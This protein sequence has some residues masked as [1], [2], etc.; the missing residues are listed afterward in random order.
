MAILILFKHQDFSW[1]PLV[2]T[3]MSIR[4]QGENTISFFV[5]YHFHPDSYWACA[6]DSTHHNIS[7][8]L[9]FFQIFSSGWFSLVTN[10]LRHLIS[11]YSSPIVLLWIFSI[12]PVWNLNPK[13]FSSSSVLPTRAVTSCCSSLTLSAFTPPEPWATKLQRACLFLIQWFF[14]SE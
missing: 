13:H 11:S 6:T 4:H 9:I 8:F 1:V 3:D 12:F 7:G 5:L 14:S 10:R 2:W